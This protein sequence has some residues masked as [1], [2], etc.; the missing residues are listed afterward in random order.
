ML[1]IDFDT[2]FLQHVPDEIRDMRDGIAGK[3]AELG[4]LARERYRELS[5]HIKELRDECDKAGHSLIVALAGKTGTRRR[6][7]SDRREE[8][9]TCVMCGTEEVGAVATRL[10]VRFLLRRAKWNFQRLNQHISRTFTDPEWYFET[11]SIIRNFSFPT[12]VVLHHAFP[13]RL[14]HSF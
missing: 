14:P 6:L 4:G 10:L 7:M 9:R 1:S 11:L 13:P 5:G 3:H 2:V 8:R 12:D